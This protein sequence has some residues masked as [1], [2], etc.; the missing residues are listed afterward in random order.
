LQQPVPP[1]S[2]SSPSPRLPPPIANADVSQTV[3]AN[4]TVMLDGRNS[5]PTQPGTRIIAYQ[6]T[7]LPIAG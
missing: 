1:L 2:P 3:D 7:Q 6:W 5:Y 4:A